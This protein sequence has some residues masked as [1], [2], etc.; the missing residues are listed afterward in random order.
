MIFLSTQDPYFFYF[1]ALNYH[2]NKKKT[3]LIKNLFFNYVD[4]TYLIISISAHYNK[5]KIHLKKRLIKN[6]CL[7]DFMGNYLLL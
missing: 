2:Y 7:C 1:F 3:F 4:F 5:H 6:N